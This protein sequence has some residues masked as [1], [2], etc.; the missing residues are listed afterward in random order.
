MKIIY[1]ILLL[2]NF[3]CD[4]NGQNESKSDN[5]NFEKTILNN[6]KRK[7][8]EDN[9]IIVIYNEDV[10]YSSGFQNSNRETMNYYI[11]YND[12]DYTPSSPL[13]IIANQEIK[14]YMDEETTNLGYF[15][16]YNRDSNAVKIKSVDFSHFNSYLITNLAYIFVGCHS[17]QNINFLNFDTSKVVN[18]WGMFSRCNSLKSL[19]LSSFDTSLV[20]NMEYMFY[21]CE[22]LESLDLSSFDTSKVKNM[23]SMFYG[24]ISLKALDLS[25]FK[26]SLL[27]K[28]QKMFEGCN[29]LESIRLSSFSSSL[30]TNTNYMFN[31]CNMLKFLDIQ[32]CDDVISSSII[33][34]FDGVE[35]LKYINIY[36]VVQSGNLAGA[37]LDALNTIDNLIVC[38]KNQIITNNNA[39]YAC[40]NY[41]NDNSK[42]EFPNSIIVKYANSVQY[43]NGFQING[44][45]GINF[46]SYNNIN[47]RN[48]EALEIPANTEIKIY[49]SSDV[50]SL[51]SFFDS[52]IDTNT[53]KIIS[54]DL[55]NFNSSL[56]T[57]VNNMFKGYSSITSINFQI[58]LLQK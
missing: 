9:Y 36:N 4:I 44:R 10:E 29:Q 46:I 14:I 13:S 22:Q 32:N 27:E 30:L 57:N 6:R 47:Y 1:I 8:Q 16:D 45:T 33:S 54:V 48:N 20:A 25:N 3:L 39:I 17:L 18:M 51:E 31:G 7:L 35:N 12:I 49:F 5:A 55:S 50:T 2:M 34:M 28:S 52:S 56:I 24:C 19:D 41:N 21:N 37:I 42:C 53:Q 23:G 58:L 26:T 15:F 38:Q 43:S 40:C 11:S